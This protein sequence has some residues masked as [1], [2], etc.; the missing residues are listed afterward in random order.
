MDEFNQ[1]EQQKKD[2]LLKLQKEL[3]GKQTE[4][5]EITNRVN[6]IKVKLARLETRKEDLEHEF[7]EEAPEN[8]WQPILSFKITERVSS[9]F[10]SGE[11]LKLKHQ[12]ELIGGIDEATTKEYEET[13]K[14]YDFLSGQSGDLNEA[15]SKLEKVIEELDGTIKQQ[16]DQAFVK[17]NHEFGRYFKTLF[18]GGRAKL[19]LVKE[20]VKENEPVLTEEESEGKPEIKEVPAE[21]KLTQ[22]KAEKIIAGIDIYAC[23]PGKK[24]KN[25]GMLSGGERALASIALI[26]AIISNNPSPFI[27]LD[28]VDAALDEANSLKFAEILNG[29]AEKTQFVVITHNRAT[30]EHSQILYGVTMGDDGISRLLSIK[31][32]DAEKVIKQ[33]GN[34]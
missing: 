2:K 21:D 3:R 24:L 28:E 27:V 8:F 22:G 26:C 17:I 32:E 15:I 12:L 9:E 16:F 18:G 14:R 11:I 33:Y 29:L 7:K 10:L 20:E 1:S 19:I 4:L 25:I 30:M 5:N 13:K 34:R 23:P 6:E 31:M